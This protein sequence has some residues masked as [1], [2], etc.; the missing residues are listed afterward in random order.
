M[1]TGN[2][3]WLDQHQR[4]PPPRPHTPHAQPEQTVRWTKASIGTSE[5]AELMAEG[6]DLEEEV[7]MC[8]QGCPESSDC[9]FRP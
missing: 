1:P 9:S 7:S 4:F 3:G 5:D 2:R 6:K 8:A